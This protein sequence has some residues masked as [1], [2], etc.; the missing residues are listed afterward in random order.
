MIDIIQEAK[1]DGNVHLE[2][3]R[4]AEGDNLR[5]SQ[6]AALIE[7]DIEVDVDDLRPGH[8]QQNVV[9]MPITQPKDVSHLNE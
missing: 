2:G 6:V 1:I 9:Q 3:G 8:V 5:H 7:E 4:Q